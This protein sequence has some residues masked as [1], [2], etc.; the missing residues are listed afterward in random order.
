M[1]IRTLKSQSDPVDIA[2]ASFYVFIWVGLL[3]RMTVR[4]GFVLTQGGRQSRGVDVMENS[5]TREFDRAE[6]QGGHSTLKV[7]PAS[8]RGGLAE[9]LCIRI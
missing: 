4:V 3:H 6:R 7:K 9:V 2:P 1:S 8:D 5:G